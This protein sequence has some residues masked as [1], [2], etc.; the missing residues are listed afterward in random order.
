MDIETIGQVSG[1]LF[2]AEDEGPSSLAKICS[3]LGNASYFMLASV[4]L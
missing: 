3:A 1:W 2:L 4:A